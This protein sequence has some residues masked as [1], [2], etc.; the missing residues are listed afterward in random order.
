V[1]MR[2]AAQH[3]LGWQPTV[4]VSGPANE[5]YILNGLGMPT[6]VFGPE[7]DNAHGADEY[8]VIESIFQA[9]AVYAHTALL[10]AQP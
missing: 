4:T 7:G 2:R 9:A 3:V 6:C 5:S 10:L 1:A 8:V